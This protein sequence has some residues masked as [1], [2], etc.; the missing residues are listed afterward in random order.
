[1]ETSVGSRIGSRRSGI[2]L[3]IDHE[4]GF[5]SIQPS[6]CATGQ[7][8]RNRRK[9]TPIVALLKP[10]ARRPFISRKPCHIDL[11]D[12]LPVQPRSH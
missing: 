9:V 8:R 12:G 2:R 10:N 3:P 1:M 5:S 4:S 7:H 6:S 11:M